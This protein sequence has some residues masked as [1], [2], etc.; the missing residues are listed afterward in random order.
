MVAQTIWRTRRVW[1]ALTEQPDATYRELAQQTGLPLSVVRAAVERLE[2]AG[3]VEA[4]PVVARGR[5]V[6][7]PLYDTRLHRPSEKGPIGRRSGVR[8]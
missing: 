8:R 6:L 5:R 7:V 1:A 4:D 3:Y 2:K